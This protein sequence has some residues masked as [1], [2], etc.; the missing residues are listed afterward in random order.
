MPSTSSRIA[1]IGKSAGA[2][3]RNKTTPWPSM[4]HR[5][6]FVS[7][8]SLSSDRNSA[9][10]G[11]GERSDTD[12]SKEYDTI[13]VLSVVRGSPQRFQSVVQYSEHPANYTCERDT[14]VDWASLI[15]TPLARQA[16][17]DQ[18]RCRVVS[19]RCATLAMSD[20]V[21]PEIIEERRI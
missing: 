20:A 12:V 4:N 10:F 16:R 19:R 13:Y 6:R 8:V 5:M 15:V 11:V 2:A 9:C 14:A 3:E 17:P 18:L 7:S 21:V 1:T